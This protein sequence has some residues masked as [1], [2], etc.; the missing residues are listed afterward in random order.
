MINNHFN[1]NNH[2]IKS[3][4]KISVNVN[5]VHGSEISENHKDEA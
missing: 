3:K 5:S 2:K 1:H 4:N